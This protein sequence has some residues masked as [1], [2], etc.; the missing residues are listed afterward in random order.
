MRGAHSGS[1]ITA[2]A[3]THSES[4]NSQREPKLTAGAQTPLA[5]VMD[6]E[7]FFSNKYLLETARYHFETKE[8][9]GS[10]RFIYF[11]SDWVGHTGFPKVPIFGVIMSLEQLE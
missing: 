3:Q 6:D 1:P 11:R 10:Y 8:S 5:L 9:I 4:P 2:G 7:N